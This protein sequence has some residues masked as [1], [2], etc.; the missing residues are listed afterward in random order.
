MKKPES[1]SV[2]PDLTSLIDVVFL[3]IIFFIMVSQFVKQENEPTIALPAAHSAAPVDRI[4][5]LI[6][7]V[8]MGGGYRVRFR[9]YSSAQPLKVLIKQQN[10][11]AVKIRADAGVPWKRVQSLIRACMECRISRVSF[12]VRPHLGARS[13][14]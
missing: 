1:R 9:D 12:G 8:P 10:I 3:L 7:N 5:R 2:K 4:D 6:I 14:L 13:G 11:R